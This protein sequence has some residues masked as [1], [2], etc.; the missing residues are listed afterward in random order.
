[1]TKTTGH[2]FYFITEDRRVDHIGNLKFISENEFYTEELP[3]NWSSL[4]VLEKYDWLNEGG[5]WVKGWGGVDTSSCGT[6][7]GAV[8][9]ERRWETADETDEYTMEAYKQSD[10]GWSLIAREEY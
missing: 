5:K 6:D 8:D 1:M 3:E 7:S 10:G 2:W 9:M 4:S